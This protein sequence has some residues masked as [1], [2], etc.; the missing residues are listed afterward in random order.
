MKQ[1]VQEIIDKINKIVNPEWKFEMDDFYGDRGGIPYP[2]I[3]SLNFLHWKRQ[4]RASD[5][6][7]LTKEEEQTQLELI[8]EI[9]E[10]KSVNVIKINAF[11]KY[12]QVEL[13]RINEK[14]ISDYDNYLLF[15]KSETN[16]DKINK[17][18]LQLEEKVPKEFISWNLF[19]SNI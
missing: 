9:A 19:N 17:I 5:Y 8:R 18:Y 7:P 15:E 12:I 2:P 16:Q 1:S 6:Y 14:I 3:E 10:I 11:G 13:Q 4:S